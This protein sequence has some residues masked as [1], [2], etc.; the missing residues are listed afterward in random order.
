MLYWRVLVDFVCKTAL[1]QYS[2]PPTFINTEIMMFTKFFAPRCFLSLSL[3]IL[4]SPVATAVESDWS[5]QRVVRATQVQLVGQA[6]YIW[7]DGSWFAPG[8][9]CE[10]KTVILLR[11]DA[12]GQEGFDQ[13]FVE[14]MAAKVTG[15]KLK[16]GAYGICDQGNAYFKATHMQSFV[17]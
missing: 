1:L 9:R 17:Q 13:M 8:H 5:D 16:F 3:L 7:T 12:S 11:P 2:R 10:H 14:V 6:L 4:S 15:A